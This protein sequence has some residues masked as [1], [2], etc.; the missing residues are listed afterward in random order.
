MKKILAHIVLPKEISPFEEEY[1]KRINT[2]AQWFFAAHLPV[3]TL[4]AWANDTGPLMALA[5]TALALVPVFLSSRVLDSPRAV[6]ITMGFSAMMMGGLLVHFGQGP[7]QIEMH[8][9]FFALLAMLSIFG[10]P[11]V[12]VVAALTAAVH[13]ALLWAYLPASIFNYEAPFWVVAVHAGFVVLESVAAS[14]IARNFFDNVIGL[15]KIIQQR[16]AQLKTRNEEMKLVMDHVDQGFITVNTEGVLSSE[17][18][19]VVEDF[20]G[21][22]PDGAKFQDILLGINERIG[23]HYELCWEQLVDGFL[24]PEMAL[25]QLPKKFESGDRSFELSYTPIISGGA[26]EKVLIVVSD[27]TAAIER[28]RLEAEQAEIMNV[29]ERVMKDKAG[30]LEFFEE[31]NDHVKDIVKNR[32]EDHAVLKRVLHTVKG[33]SMLFGINTVGELCHK[34]EDSIEQTGERPDVSSRKEL[35]IRWEH[36]KH[37]LETV[38]GEGGARIEIEDDEFEVVLKDILSPGVSREQIA[39]RVKTWK[40]ERAHVRLGRIADQAKSIAKRLNKPELEVEI[41]DGDVRLDPGYWAPFWSS[42][43]HVVRN[44]VDHGI[45]DGSEREAAG[46]PQMGKL[47]LST[48]VDAEGLVVSITDDGKGIDWN[49]VANKA[50]SLG[51]PANDQNDLVEALFS[52]GMSTKDQVTSYSGRGVGMGAVREACKERQGQ[53]KVHSTKGEGTVFEFRFPRDQMQQVRQASLPPPSTID[54][55]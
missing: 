28:R 42:F 43:V 14:F 44:A 4:V 23:M 12:I 5:L 50:Q 21:E 22:I 30:F 16:T 47:K 53:V 36:I 55:A 20:F 46:K 3:F 33:N 13:H 51:I 25:D 31:A 6:S 45:E 18:S 40:L 11:M 35:H 15:D 24:P 8:F 52:E 9:Y 41:D 7:V 32:I 10:N 39:D 27:V 48:R 17:R 19:R 54:V 38:I 2:I 49:M 34:M 26:L 29:F 37:N 1:L